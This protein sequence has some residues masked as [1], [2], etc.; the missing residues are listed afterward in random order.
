[1]DNKRKVANAAAPRLP[2]V[3]RSNDMTAQIGDRLFVDG[4]E[5]S[6]TSF[7]ALPSRVRRKST[8]TSPDTKIEERD[9]VP[10]LAPDLTNSTACWRGYVASWTIQD[11][12]LYLTE[13]M[14]KY[15][16]NSTEPV[17]ADWFSGTLR[18][19]QGECIEYIHMGFASRYERERWLTIEKG[20]L[21]DDCVLNAE[22]IEK[23]T[24]RQQSWLTALLAQLIAIAIGVVLGYGFIRIFH[25]N[26]IS[27]L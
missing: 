2:T 6:M 1:M 12:R 8:K 22:E 26:L 23:A 21:V 15:E 9:G 17:L 16:L 5:A 3:I 7:P 4:Q 10:Y 24:K 11:D 20:V 14:G 27:N 25:P 18:I 13:I 19:P